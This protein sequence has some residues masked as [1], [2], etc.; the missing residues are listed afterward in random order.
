[1]R[2]TPGEVLRAVLRARR[3]LGFKTPV[4]PR[5]R[6]VYYDEE[7]DFLLIVVA[8]RPDKSVVL[9]PGGR[10]LKLVKDELGVS[11]M[12]ARSYTDLLVKRRRIREALARAEALAKRAGG[13]LGA[14]LERVVALLRAE[15][16]YPLRKWPVFEPLGEHALAVAYSG[17]IDSTAMLHVAKRIGLEPLAIT[18]DAGGWMLPREVRGWISDVVGRLGVEHM[19]VKGDERV[20]KLVL[21]WA[22]AGRR[23]PCKMCHEEIERAVLDR[24]LEEGVP[25]VGFGDLLPTGRFSI[26]W[27]RLRG[28]RLLRLNLLAALALFK[29]DTILM[30]KEAGRPVERLFFGC[31]L[32]KL[33]HRE[34]KEMMLPSIQRVLREARAGILEPNQ[35][36]ELIKSIVR[37]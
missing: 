7:G 1:M 6:A 23:H 29:T 21:E 27:I 22:R 37:A 9:G 36:L 18:V 33:V 2:F 26:Y 35:A 17:G 12:A 11:S 16:A 31:Q 3:A 25:M 19:Y 20:F 15:L 34:H 30:A 5:I 13:L 8:D 28:R 32:L 14:A 24:A 10:V 4:R